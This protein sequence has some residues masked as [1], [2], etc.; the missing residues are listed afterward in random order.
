MNREFLAWEPTY[1]TVRRTRPAAISPRPS[2][3][4]DDKLSERRPSVTNVPNQNTEVR[5]RMVGAIM[6]LKPSPSFGSPSY[7]QARR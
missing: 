7:R 4:T 1:D 6:E 2:S 5:G 3:S